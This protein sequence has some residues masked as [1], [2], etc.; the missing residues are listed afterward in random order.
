MRRVCIRSQKKSCG[1]GRVHGK[2]VVPC[3]VIVGGL[4]LTA[5]LPTNQAF[6]LGKYAWC[7]GEVARWAPAQ[8]VLYFG[9]P[10]CSVIII[11]PRYGIVD[12]K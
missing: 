5:A 7:I 8:A 4:D 10:S 6:F 9:R 12:T 1:D 11:I 2:D 3:G